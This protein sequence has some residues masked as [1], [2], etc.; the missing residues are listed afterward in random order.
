MTG[1]RA[2]LLLLAGTLVYARTFA[3][4]FV[5]DD[6]H[7]IV[8]NLRIREWSSELLMAHRP[9]V[10]ITLAFNYMLGGL[11]VVGYHVLNLVLHLAC[12]LLLYDVARRTLRFTGVLGGREDWTAFFAALLFLVHPLQT[13]SVTYVISRS[14]LLMALCYLATLD[15]ALLAETHPRR[16]YVLWTIAVATCAFGMTAKPIMAT[17]PLAVWWLSYCVLP[18][19][20]RP[21]L[22]FATTPPA[23]EIPRRWPLHLGL[24]LTWLVLVVLLTGGPHPGAGLDIDL[25]PVDYFRTQLG[26]TWHY[27][28]LLVWPVGQTLDYDWPIATRW[29]DP[30]V[31]APALGWLVVLASLVWLAR[32]GRRLAAFWLGFAI[33]ALLPSSSFVPIADLAFEHRMYLTVG[34]FAVLAAL[35][36]GGLATVAPRTVAVAGIA[37]AAAFGWLTIARN[38]LWRDP[39]ALWTD[40]LAKTPAKQRVYRNLEEAY[41]RRGDQDGIRRVVVAEIETLE[42][43]HRE[44]R[45]PDAGRPSRRGGAAT[46]DGGGFDRRPY[47]LDRARH[48]A[49]RGGESRMGVRGDRSHGRRAPGAA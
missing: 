3:V 48:E 34:G 23:V 24:V 49:D 14:E 46:R 17:A 42:R 30:Y 13:E 40:N 10:E 44:R 25:E 41:Q 28:R 47:G 27:F 29:S 6:A 45:A 20:T 7:A 4:P 9:L 36:G 12:G 1:L 26:V 39:V 21:R 15:L 33:L 8:Q 11:N 32:R 38:E 37:I 16:R 35:A 31:V 18:P 2:L 5:F 19:P 43:L 22:A